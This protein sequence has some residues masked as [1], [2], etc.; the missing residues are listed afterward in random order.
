MLLYQ[1]SSCNGNTPDIYSVDIK[2]VALVEIYCRGFKWL[3]TGHEFL[4]GLIGISKLVIVINYSAITNSHTLQFVM[5]RTES[6]QSA[7][8]SS[9][10]A[11]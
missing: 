5:V 6:S 7:V 1:G 3:D 8:S 10:F 2:M 11:W 4:I 9:N